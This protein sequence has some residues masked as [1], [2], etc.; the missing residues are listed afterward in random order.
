MF[1]DDLNVVQ[2]DHSDDQ[3]PL[4]VLRQ[5]VDAGTMCDA[6]KLK[7]KVMRD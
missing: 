6:N 7:W 4:E 1:L 3:P 2:S 5:V